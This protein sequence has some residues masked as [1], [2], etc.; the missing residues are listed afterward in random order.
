PAVGGLIFLSLLASFLQLEG[1]FFEIVNYL[2]I[3]GIAAVII[4][5]VVTQQME[6][7]VAKRLGEAAFTLFIIATM[8]FLL[9][10]FL[11]GGPFD[12]DKALPTEVI[13]NIEAKYGL[14]DP[15]HIQYL[16]Y[17]K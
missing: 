8:T 3:G 6:I 10:R 14:D 2:S 4:Y 11:P 13:A 12:S 5:F 7:Y 1:S 16:N 17:M 15:L 9:L